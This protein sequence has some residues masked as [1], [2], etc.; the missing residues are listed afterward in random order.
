MKTI[1][2]FFLFSVSILCAQNSDYRVEISS[3][4]IVSSENEIPFWL[5]ANT[6]F[7]FSEFT[8]FSGVL[9][10]SYTYK[11]KNASLEAGAYIFARD[12]VDKNVQ[13]RDLYLEFKNDWLKVTAGAKQ[14]DEAFFGLSSTNQNYLYS[15]NARP[16]PGVII[17]ANEPLKI[18]D[19]FK[20]DWGIAHYELNDDRFVD[21]ARVHYKRLNLITQLSKKSKLTLGIQHFA[22]WAGTSPNFGTL[23]SDLGGFWNVFIANRSTE[24]GLDGEIQNAVGNHLGSYLFRYDLNSSKGEIA[25]YHEHPFE[26]GSGTA[27]KNFPDGVWGLTFKPAGNKI[28]KGVLYEYVDT[29]D[30]SSSSGGNRVDNYFSNGIYESGWTY[31]E[32]IIGIPFF[33][34][35]KDIIAGEGK[36]QIIGSRFQ[37]HHFGI[38]GTISSVDW[39]LRTSYSK[40]LGTYQGVFETIHEDFYTALELRYLY[41]SHHQFTLLSGMDISNTSNNI[42]AGGGSYTYTF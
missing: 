6:G 9:D 21:G 20:I 32:N 42:I 28:I 26:D 30:Q 37:V 1:F 15:N 34:I 12:G 3:T 22:Q 8:N 38:T 5:S 14:R 10:G 29:R 19:R 13:R 40:N 16:L 24:L 2:A 31:E 36:R 17:E 18:T 41:K 4:A 27:F 23:K 35:D 11:L 7:E 25:F 39:K 33:E